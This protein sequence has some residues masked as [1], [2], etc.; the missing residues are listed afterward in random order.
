M[1]D[2]VPIGIAIAEDPQGYHIRGNPA[3]EQLLGVMRGGELS[4]LPGL[5]RAPAGF[6]TLQNGR[7][8]AI[9]ELPMQRAVRGEIVTGQ[10]LDVVRQ[11]GRVVNL[12]SNAVPL[13]DEQNRPRGA[14]GAFLDITDLRRAE[15]ALRRAK[16]ELELR[17]QERTAELAKTN[18]ALLAENLERKKAHDIVVKQTRLLQAFFK[19]T[20]TPLVF[21]DK[22][23]NFI[24]VNE[25]YARA[26][27]REEQEFPGRNHFEL[28]PNEENQRIFE[29]VVATG[30]DLPGYSQAVCFSRPS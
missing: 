26:C 17:V 28:Y 16:D 2:T 25:A 3:N 10:I 19:S 1:F 21:L 24:R 11:D 7:E 23:F 9:E 5:D 15:E 29:Q 8:L 13:Y 30:E 6:R 12:Y 27:Q 20:I 4:L 14:V 22:N 18:E